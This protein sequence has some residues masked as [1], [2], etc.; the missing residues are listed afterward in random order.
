MPGIKVDKVCVFLNLDGH[1]SQQNGSSIIILI[2]YWFWCR[3]WF[4][5]LDPTMNH[6]AKVLMVWR[7]GAPSTT[8]RGHASRSG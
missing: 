4:H 7:P 2:I 6:G 5:C 3:V 8:S 1:V